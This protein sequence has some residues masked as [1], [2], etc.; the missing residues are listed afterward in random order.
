MI[1]L[2][3]LGEPNVWRALPGLTAGTPE[4]APARIGCD[5]VLDL[6]RGEEH[7][8]TV[9]IQACGWNEGFAVW[10][11]FFDE[12]VGRKQVLRNV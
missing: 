5:Q 10:L 6:C 12:L 4:R 7:G 3:A 11:A 2:G 1:D 9:G 8:W